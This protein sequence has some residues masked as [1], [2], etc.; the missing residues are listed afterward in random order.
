MTTYL[1][2]DLPTL[3]RRFI[4]YDQLFD[5]LNRAFSPTTK[6]DNYPP[7]NVIRT[8]ENTY[9]IDVAVA[10]FSEQELDVALEGRKLIVRGDRSRDEDNEYEYMHRGISGRNF[11][12]TFPLGDNVEVSSAAVVNGILSIQLEHIVPEDEKPKRIA[13]TFKK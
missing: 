7:Y 10:G 1:T 5:E 12:K 6:Q 9:Q 3:H 11:E 13:I 8:G 4:G 2:L